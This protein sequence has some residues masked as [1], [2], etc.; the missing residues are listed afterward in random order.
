MNIRKCGC[1][2][3]FTKRTVHQL[4][5]VKIVP[6]ED[7]T[8]QAC[9][10]NALSGHMDQFENL[11]KVQGPAETTVESHDVFVPVTER[12]TLNEPTP[13]PTMDILHSNL[14]IQMVEEKMAVLE[15]KMKL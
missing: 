9:N 1:V 15:A 3:D 10:Q 5:V 13:A 14:L 2:I 7:V 4:P 8:V 6:T 11:V 12:S